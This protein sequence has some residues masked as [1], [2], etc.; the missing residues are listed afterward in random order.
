MVQL[1]C[2]DVINPGA[3][4]GSNAKELFLKAV[5]TGAGQPNAWSPCLETLEK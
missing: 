1:I 5:S 2:G 3:K 4:R